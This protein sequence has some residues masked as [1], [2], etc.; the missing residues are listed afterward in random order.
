MHKVI[1]TS[2]IAACVTS[3][4][5]CA[6]TD[7]E[8]TV[9]TGVAEDPANASRD[10]KGNVNCPAGDFECQLNSDPALKRQFDAMANARNAASIYVRSTMA[11]PGYVWFEYYDYGLQHWFGVEV[12][13]TAPKEHRVT[14]WTCD[15]NGACKKFVDAA[16]NASKWF[17]Y[18]VAASALGRA[19][20]S[21]LAALVDGS[22]LAAVTANDSSVRDG[23]ARFQSDGED[24]GNNVWQTCNAMCGNFISGAGA[25]VSVAISFISG[26]LASGANTALEIFGTAGTYKGLSYQ[27]CSSDCVS[28]YQSIKSECM[29][30]GTRWDHFS[31]MAWTCGKDGLPHVASQCVGLCRAN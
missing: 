1:L 22:F 17:D 23:W 8:A 15:G 3:M 25:I 13:R 30:G 19:N 6:P 9:A 2:F 29:S 31:C 16:T 11:S 18:S 5:G 4:A 10:L 26:L 7:S 21:A 12:S 24:V 27:N 14:R 20:D 28:C